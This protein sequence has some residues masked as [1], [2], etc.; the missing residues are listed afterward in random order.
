M[1]ETLR[2]YLNPLHVFCRLK[3]CGVPSTAARRICCVYERV[4]CRML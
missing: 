3:S 2:H 1:K 4:Y